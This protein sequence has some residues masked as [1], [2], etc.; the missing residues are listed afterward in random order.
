MSLIDIS[1]LT[2]SYEGSYD[3]IFQNVNLQLDTE[4]RLGLVGRNGRGKTTFLNLLRNEF[5]YSGSISSSVEFEYFPYNVPDSSI[6]TVDVVYSI[7]PDCME[8]EII[9]EIALLNVAEDVLYRPFSTLSGGERSKVLLAALFIHSKYF[10]LIDEPTNHLDLDAKKEVARYLKKKHGFILVSHDRSLLDECVDHILSINRSNIDIQKGNFSSWQLNKQR[11]DSFEAAE[12]KKLHGEIQR[13]SAAAKKTEI[14]ASKTERGK[15]GTDNSGSKVDRGYVG[16]KSAKMMKR[17][18]SIE[19]RQ[20]AAITEKMTLLRNI[21]EYDDLKLSPLLYHKDILVHAENLTLL[22]G[23]RTLLCGIDFTVRRGDRIAISGAN[24]CGKSCILKLIKGEQLNYSG[25]L[26][27]GSGL[28][29]SYVP[30]DASTLEG[31]LEDYAESYQI[32]GILFRTILFKMGF[33]RVQFEKDM[34]A[35]SSGQKKKAMIARS[36]CEQAH[37][38]IWDEP[39]NYIDIFSRIQIENL[40]VK[41]EPTLLFVEHDSVFRD[42]TATKTIEL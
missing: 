37:L 25:K 16:H 26:S 21:D 1:N 23:D 8:W 42:N 30:Q 15:F 5:S 31:S 4:W 40:I 3:N 6:N 18:K 39:L 2:F 34:S 13:L 14:W 33:D 35:F 10:L 22:F 17:T 11:Q 24:G 7:C 36:L 12:N 41:H 32:D 20:Q 28:K 9:K 27:V 38:Y 19:S 29:I